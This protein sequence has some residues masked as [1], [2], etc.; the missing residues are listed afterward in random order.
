MTK[1]DKAKGCL[2]GQVAGDSLGSLVEF[3][4]P[5]MIKTRYPNGLTDLQ[6][7]GVWE[8]LSGQATDDSEMAITLARSIIRNSN[9]NQFEVLK[10]YQ[11]WLN[12]KPFDCGITI[13][14][15]LNGIK[16]EHSQANGALMRV[17]PIGILGANFSFSDIT[18]WAK[19]DAELTHINNVCVQTNILFASVIADAISQTITPLDLYTTLLQRAKDINADL[20]IMSVIEEA[21]TQP[22]SDYLEKQGWVL[23]AFHNAI[24][25]MLNSKNPYQAIVDTA[26]QGGDTDTNSAICGALMGAIYGIEAFPMQ[27]Q[28]AVL[29][30][31]PSE[32]IKGVKRPR[33]QEYWTC[34]IFDI[35][36]QLLMI[37]PVK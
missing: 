3:M 31:K 27:W 15:A 34:D 37:H 11:R 19:K 30:C 20:S 10:S 4:T 9:Y 26:S 16:S 8:T 35:A 13:S 14:K 24:W 25:H 22:P 12:S 17:A 21:K 32:K 1:I 18:D 29:N 5:V 28:N 36:E 33:P 7:G 23:I 2:M 6:D